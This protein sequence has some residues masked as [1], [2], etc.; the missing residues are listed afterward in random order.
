M[1]IIF[2]ILVIILLIFF[3]NTEHFDE[4]NSRNYYNVSQEEQD[5]PNRKRDCVI[6]CLN[7]NNE[8]DNNCYNKC[9]ITAYNC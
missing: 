8:L 9:L 1:L 6:A 2:I 5:C 4:N 3:Y 7:K